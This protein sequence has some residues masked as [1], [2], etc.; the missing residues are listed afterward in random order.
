[1]SARLSGDD[2]IGWRMMIRRMMETEGEGCFE[3]IRPDIH[4]SLR[5]SE[6]QRRSLARS[7]GTCELEYHHK[8]YK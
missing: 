6:E 8:H 7:V 2:V 3:Q 5:P 4:P 1:M